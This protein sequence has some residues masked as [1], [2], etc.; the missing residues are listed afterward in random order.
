VAHEAPSDAD[1]ASAQKHVDA[2]LGELSRI[3]VQAPAGTT[4]MLDGSSVAGAAPLGDPLDVMPGH[5]VVAATLAGGLARSSDVDAVA[6]ELAQVSFAA[7]PP[8]PVVLVATPAAAPVAPTAARPLPDVP[9]SPEASPTPFWTARTV[10]ATVFAGVAVAAGGAAAA[11]GLASQ[12][13]KSAVDNYKGKYSSSDCLVPAGKAA[14][15][16]C[17]PWND[18]VNAQNRDANISNALYFAAGA[19]ALGAVVSWFFWPKEGHVK[20]A[21]VVP[22]VGPQTASVEAGGR[23]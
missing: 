8:A 16:E 19:L 5:H 18:A 1:R 15:S 9:P 23:F 7:D 4:F 20:A 10:T 17:A 11:F 14:P 3:E 13:N 22:A 2:L 12:N 21:W 6:G